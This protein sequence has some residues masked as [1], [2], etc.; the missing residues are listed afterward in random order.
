MDISGELKLG[1]IRFGYTFKLRAVDPV[2]A[3]QILYHHAYEPLAGL[4]SHWQERTIALQ[5]LI[6]RK[7]KELRQWN[8]FAE[9]RGFK[10]AHGNGV[11]L[12][13]TE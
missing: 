13:R 9:E 3:S 2:V 11:P 10:A 6:T 5:K 4:L 12:Q 8:E 7:D 1:M